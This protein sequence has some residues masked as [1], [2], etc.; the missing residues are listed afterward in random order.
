MR[1]AFTTHDAK[2]KDY[3]SGNAKRFA[4]R[5]E[6]QSTFWPRLEVTYFVN[7]GSEANDLAVT[8]AR[9]YTGNADIIAV[10]NG[11]HGGSPTA[12]ALTDPHPALK[13]ASPQAS[14]ADMWLG[15]DFHHNGA[16]RLSYGFEYAAMMETSKENE[17]FR[18]PTYDTYEWYL[19]LGSLTNVN[20][21]VL[22]GKIPTW[23]DFVAHPNFD[24]FWKRQTIISYISAAPRVPT[25]NVAG[26]WDQE[27][28][29][30]PQKIYELL[31]K[32]DANK[33]NYLVV[34]PWNHGG[35]NRAEGQ[36]LGKIDKSKQ[37][38]VLSVLAEMF[39]P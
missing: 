33:M 4:S 35:W 24:E 27:D 15:D 1:R 39:A 36:K 8:M 16:F 5:E 3:E 13:A 12:M 21:S 29:Y 7:S 34:G 26:W 11:Y 25:L 6:A 20:K 22:N 32:H 19:T 9:L 37:E 14:P 2:S 17:Q 38:E 31:E 30:G 18:F 28:F 23:N 10:R